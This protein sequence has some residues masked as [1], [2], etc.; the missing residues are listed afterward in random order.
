MK[1]CPT[2]GQTLPGPVP[3]VPVTGNRARLL[4]IVQKAGKH[5]ITGTTL[6]DR[7]YRGV[8]NGGP[9]SRNILSVMV[10]AINKQLVK[11]GKHIHVTRGPSPNI[12]TLED[13]DGT[14][15]TNA[16]RRA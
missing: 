6:F 16:K 15:Q 8:R 14:S 7:L 9:D 4:Q 13:I 5:G 3:L 11:I 2:C 12:Y 1:C 10:C